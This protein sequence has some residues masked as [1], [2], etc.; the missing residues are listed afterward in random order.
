MGA[1]K[2]KVRKKDT[3]KAEEILSFTERLLDWGRRHGAVLLGAVGGILCVLVISWAV[4]EYSDM[5]ELNARRELAAV[6]RETESLDPKDAVSL[7]PHLERLKTVA[8]GHKG[9]A[10]SAWAAATVA[11]LLFESG[12]YEEALP[13]YV[14]AL[15]D[16]PKK[17]AGAMLI[18]YGRL[19]CLEAMG[20]TEEALA[21]WTALADTV[22]GGLRREALWHQ[23]RLTAA[24]GER[25]KALQ[26]YDAALAVKGF[27][28]DDGFLRTEKSRLGSMG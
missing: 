10:A 28:P 7:D 11:R 23:A 12:R 2:I 20:R 13:W 18:D 22:E 8:D 14:R 19:M 9:T 6:W 17:A 16:F 27:Y 15:K 4:G 3:E 26:L 21:G 24:K 5:R 25:D 1:K